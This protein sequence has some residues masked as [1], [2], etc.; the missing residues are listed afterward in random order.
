MTVKG[1]VRRVVLR[2]EMVCID[3]EVIAKSG[4]GK[5][6]SFIPSSSGR[7]KKAPSVCITTAS[8]TT[9]GL[10]RAAAATVT[11]VVTSPMN[12]RVDLNSSSPTLKLKPAPTIRLS[13]HL[14]NAA[15]DG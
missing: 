12:E 5:H 14:R 3:G 7:Q 8:P 2:G 10:K 1:C 13:N 11:T 15:T 9:N 4:Y 6:V